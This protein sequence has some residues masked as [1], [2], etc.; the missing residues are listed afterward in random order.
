MGDNSIIIRLEEIA[1][2]YANEEL[3]FD[4]LDFE[5][6]QGEKIGL[7]GDNG[8][9]KTTLLQIIIGI[10]P[11]QSGRIE[12]LGETVETENDFH[13]ARKQVGLLFQHS[14]DQ[15]FCPT[16]L[17]DVAFG[18]LNLGKKP[19][20]AREIA[21]KTLKDLNLGG[22]E[23]RITHQ[24]SG[25]EKKLVALATILAMRPKI[26]LLD[27]PTSGLDM[28]TRARLA[29]ILGQLDVSYIMVSHEYDF[30]AR[31]TKTV[32]C[33]KGGQI[34]YRGKSSSLHSHY[35]NHS[36]GDIPHEHA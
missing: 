3:V 28:D 7:I 34:A 1:F 32:Y 2:S 26:L 22:F 9:G 5:L 23:D 10:L 35:H 36:A 21:L 31:N 15:L 12:I 18:P 11:A 6:R 4:K 30:L 14:D 16:V 19:A 8:S 25:G 29:D 33:L 27:E 13:R 20:E 17:E 24:L